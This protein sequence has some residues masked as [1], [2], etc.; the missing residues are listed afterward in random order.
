MPDGATRQVRA[1]TGRDSAIYHNRK[2]HEKVEHKKRNVD[3]DIQERDECQNEKDGGRLHRANPG[4]VLSA[5]ASERAVLL[6][7]GRH[8]RLGLRCPST[9]CRACC[10]CS[11]GPRTPRSRGGWED[12]RLILINLELWVF[13]RTDKVNYD[14]EKL[15]SQNIRLAVITLSRVNAEAEET[16]QNE[17]GRPTNL[18]VRDQP[19]RNNLESCYRHDVRRKQISMQ[20][21]P[22]Q[23]HSRRSS[24]RTR[25]RRAVNC[26]AR[27]RNSKRRPVLFPALLGALLGSLV[28]VVVVWPL[29]RAGSSSAACDDRQWERDVPNLYAFG[30]PESL[31]TDS[32]D[33]ITGLQVRYAAS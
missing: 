7:L 6:I 30:G 24:S 11:G 29:A 18:N 15:K 8:F 16:E 17:K 21:A 12:I 20:V 3:S 33:K 9:R 27:M 26:G 5:L 28:S 31:Q 32:S 1:R 25:K 22:R 4:V 14:R 19:I 10:N 23:A 13:C 2:E